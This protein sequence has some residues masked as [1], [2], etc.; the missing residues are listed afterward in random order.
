MRA[1]PASTLQTLPLPL[2]SVA[3]MQAPRSP[4]FFPFASVSAQVLH[5]GILTKPSLFQSG[6]TRLCLT[7]LCVHLLP[8]SSSRPRSRWG[9]LQNLPGGVRT[10]KCQT[11]LR[12]WVRQ[13]AV[14][15]VLQ[16]TCELGAERHEFSV[17]ILVS[18]QQAVI[19]CL[20][21]RKCGRF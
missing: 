11:G 18:F 1:K 8:R 19:E 5:P 12:K 13:V 14:R 17:L 10:Q 3:P 9:P 7:V 21:S 4:A 6:Q 15:Y 2:F 16:G 20:C